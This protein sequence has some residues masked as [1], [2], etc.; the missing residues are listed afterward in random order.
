ML[1]TRYN[2][3]MLFVHLQEKVWSGHE[4][5]ELAICNSG[6]YEG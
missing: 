3:E 5:I 6:L 1:T 2:Q 4:T